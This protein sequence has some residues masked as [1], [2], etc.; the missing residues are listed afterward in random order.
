[1]SKK[2]PKKFWCN[3]CDAL[4]ECRE[5]TTKDENGIAWTWQKCQTCNIIFKWHTSWIRQ[6]DFIPQK[7]EKVLEISGT[8]TGALRRMDE[9]KK[10]E[11]AK[12][13]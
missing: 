10:R 1:M 7:K 3:E 4:R 11:A 5:K 2:A 6:D 12:N 13:G 9:R 8:K